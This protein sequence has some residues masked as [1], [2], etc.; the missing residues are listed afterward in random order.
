MGDRKI[1]FINKY[2]DVVY[3]FLNAMGE[4]ELSVEI[5]TVSN[6]DDA[7]RMLDQN[8]YQIVVTGLTLD[9]Y[10]GEQIV[11][12]VN[13]NY[14]NSVCIIYTTT[15]S[16]AQLH[17]FMNERNVFRVFLRPVN[18]RGEFFQALEEAFEYYE[19]RVKDQEDADMRENAYEE[20]RKGIVSIER[21]L[22]NQ[23]RAQQMMERYLRRLSLLTL[24]EYSG[25]AGADAA[26]MGPREMEGLAKRRDR[27]WEIVHLCCKQDQAY[28]E[29]LQ[30]AEEMTAEL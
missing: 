14:P 26:G 5:D 9:G 13:Q 11:T 8:T 6:G 27:E 30:R 22:A 1:L 3:E 24:K 12:Y 21:K 2:Q 23:P 28:E 19:V 20:N 16:A 29:H 17:F 15:I 10:N 7:I 4:N 18:F 25:L